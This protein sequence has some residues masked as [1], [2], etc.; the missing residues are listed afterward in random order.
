MS[1]GEQVLRSPALAALRI[2]RG[3][4]VSNIVATLEELRDY[5]ETGAAIEARTRTAYRILA[6]ACPPEGG[7]QRP[8]DDTHISRSS[9][10]RRH[11]CQPPFPLGI[12]RPRSDE[13]DLLQPRT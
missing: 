4:S 5:G 2:R 12:A 1:V 13:V 7:G 10:L 9:H 11:G 3:P 8:V 6:L